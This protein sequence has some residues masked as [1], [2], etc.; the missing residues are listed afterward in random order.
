MSRQA[1]RQDP[2][3]E[4]S[5]ITWPR[6]YENHL[7]I[8][9]GILRPKPHSNPFWFARWISTHELEIKNRPELPPPFRLRSTLFR[10]YPVPYVQPK[11]KWP[12]LFLKL[13]NFITLMPRSG[14]QSFLRVLTQISPC[15][16]T[17]GWKIF[18]RKYP[19][20][21]KNNIAFYDFD[22]TKMNT[23]S[24]KNGC[25]SKFLYTFTNYAS[26]FFEPFVT[27][28]SSNL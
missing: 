26:C 27:R 20:G 11:I 3:P 12:S 8:R 28:L 7:W 21:Y 6:G 10:R 22:L 16:P 24:P 19:F 5:V 14:F 17:L 4:E 15:W 23:S 18:V 1:L 2:D 25:K 13:E 9:G